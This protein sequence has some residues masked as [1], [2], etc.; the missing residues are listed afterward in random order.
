M[1]HETSKSKRL[2]ALRLSREKAQQEL[3]EAQ[4][5]VEELKAV[6]LTLTI[7]IDSMEKAGRSAA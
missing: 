4:S 3:R 7:E 5:R 2:A 1:K 6:N